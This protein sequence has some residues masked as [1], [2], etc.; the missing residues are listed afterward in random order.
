MSNLE[1][2]STHSVKPEAETAEQIIRITDLLAQRAMGIVE[3]SRVTDGSIS[4]F[5]FTRDEMSPPG[6]VLE[7]NLAASGDRNSA[8]TETLMLFTEDKS[9]VFPYDVKNREITSL[10][11]SDPKSGSQLVKLYDDGIKIVNRGGKNNKFSRVQVVRG[12]TPQLKA[13]GKRMDETT[14]QEADRELET[15]EAR[16]VSAKALGSIRSK[17]AKIDT[18]KRN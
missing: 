14:G 2:S 1:Q 9:S 5:P 8:N 6:E 10:S 13:R 12:E 16:D 4:D 17:I 11:S 7:V 18:G 3:V 15:Q